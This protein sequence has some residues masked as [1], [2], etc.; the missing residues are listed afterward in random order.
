M[1]LAL[2]ITDVRI[3]TSK[4]VSPQS[5]PRSFMGGSPEKLGFSSWWVRLTP[6]VRGEAWGIT[7]EERRDVGEPSLP[8]L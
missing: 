5:H 2:Q 3:A 7:L 8:P 1:R 6:R 4:L